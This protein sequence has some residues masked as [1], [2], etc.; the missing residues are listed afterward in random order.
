M[1]HITCRLTAK[2]RDQLRSPEPCAGLSSMGYVYPGTKYPSHAGDLVIEYGLRLPRYEIP[3]S[4]RRLG[5]SAYVHIARTGLDSS[6]ENNVLSNGNVH[7]TRVRN[8][9]VQGRAYSKRGPCSEKMWGPL[10]YEYAVTPSM[11]PARHTK[12]FPLFRNHYVNISG[13]LPC[14]KKMKKKIVLLF[15]RTC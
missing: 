5:A 9:S 14:C 15:G 4:R 11:T 8:S 7:I 6:S 12:S 1:T 13:L 10:I 3:Q 2:N